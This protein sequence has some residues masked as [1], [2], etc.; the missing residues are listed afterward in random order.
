[1]GRNQLTTADVA[2]R[3]VAKARFPED[4]DRMAKVLKKQHRNLET[5]NTTLNAPSARS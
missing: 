2:V 4:I 3:E 5:E 1:M